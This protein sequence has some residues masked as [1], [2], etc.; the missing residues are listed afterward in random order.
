[1]AEVEQ[2]AATE[3]A[4]GFLKT[5]GGR[6]AMA[7]AVT[8]VLTLAAIVI[9]GDAAYLWIKAVHVVAVMSWMAGLLYLPRIFV[10]HSDAAIGGETSETLKVMERRLYEIIMTPAMVITWVLGLWLA[11]TLNAF[12]EP[13]LILKLIAVIAMSAFHDYLK[14]AIRQFAADDV[15]VRNARR[16]RFL[17]EVPTLLMLAIVILVIVKPF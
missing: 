10:Y 7:L 1:M 15:S 5:P 6:A 2:P 9:M 3:P 4:S 12:L 17:N 16:W 8:V 14:R 11:Y 13:W